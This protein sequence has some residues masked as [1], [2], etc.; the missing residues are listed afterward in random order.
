MTCDGKGGAVHS[1]TGFMFIT[2]DAKSN[3][4][5]RGRKVSEPWTTEASHPLAPLSFSNHA[6]RWPG[7]RAP[8]KPPAMSRLFLACLLAVFP[9]ALARPQPLHPSPRGPG[10]APQG[11]QPLGEQPQAVKGGWVS[12]RWGVRA[13]NATLARL[14]KGLHWE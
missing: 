14:A 2:G 11:S 13:G 1:L 3:G 6:G 12:Q 5:Y 4:C 7:G 8:Q 9:G 10:A